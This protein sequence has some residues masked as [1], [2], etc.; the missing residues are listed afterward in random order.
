MFLFRRMWTLVLWIWKTVECFKWDLMD[1]P[2]RNMED[3]GAEADLN[4][5][6]SRGFRGKEF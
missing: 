5:G 2:S 4:C 3:I 1:H 6:G